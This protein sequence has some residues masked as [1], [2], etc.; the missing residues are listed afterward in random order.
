MV[1]QRSKDF[2]VAFSYDRQVEKV[3]TRPCNRTASFTLQTSFVFF[4]RSRSAKGKD[5]PLQPQCRFFSTKLQRIFFFVRSKSGKGKDMPLQSQRRLYSTN[6]LRQNMIALKNRERSAAAPIQ[7][8]K[9]KVRQP[10]TRHDDYTSTR[11]RR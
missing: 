9:T 8:R 4:L 7:A 3:R 10:H 2:V 11:T 1:D 6:L 5:V